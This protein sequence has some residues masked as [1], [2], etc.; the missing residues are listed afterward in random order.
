MSPRG[1]LYRISI[2]SVDTFAQL[3]LGDIFGGGAL[4]LS[5]GLVSSRLNSILVFFYD[6]CGLNRVKE[7]VV[8]SDRRCCAVGLAYIRVP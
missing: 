7:A 4:S 1:F 6:P 2:S 8:D 3:G 5:L